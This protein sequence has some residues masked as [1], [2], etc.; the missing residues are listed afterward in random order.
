MKTQRHLFTSAAALLPLLIA[1]AA[2]H[3]Q[4]D[5]KVTKPAPST[6]SVNAAPASPAKV[7]NPG[8]EFSKLGG[9]IARP[10]IAAPKGATSLLQASAPLNSST[11]ESVLVHL[12]QQNQA[13]FVDILTAKGKQAATRRATVR[14]RDPLPT[15]PGNLQVAMRYLE[16]RKKKGPVIVLSDDSMNYVLAFPKGFGTAVTQQ[17]FVNTSKNGTQST[18][19]FNDLDGR[20]FAIVKATVVSAAGVA[21]GD[22]QQYFVWNGSK[23]IPRR[24]N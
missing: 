6:I 17:Q 10:A 23:F 22:A 8:I 9:N 3:A 21:P 20:G 14:L 12:Y 2:C 16:P 5:V 19:N 11:G 18:Y 15:S 7:E 4:D 1:S 13:L 24:E